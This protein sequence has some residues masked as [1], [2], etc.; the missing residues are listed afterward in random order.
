M[1]RYVALLRG[2]TPSNPNMRSEKLRKVFESL[3]FVNA[4]TVLASGNVLF[5][6]RSRNRRTLETKIER[7]LLGQLG[8][9][10]VAVVRSREQLLQL[11]AG[12]PFRSFKDAPSSR[13]NVTFLKNP[14]H[15]TMMFPYWAPDRTYGLLVL[16]EGAICSVVNLS[17]ATT[18]ELMRW[19]ESHFG[20]EITTRTWKTV[21]RILRGM[22]DS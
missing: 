13:L 7:A 19:L 15:A 12:D 17:G 5:Q 2:I 4:R 14:P 9:S 22:N 10:S 8:F 1:V 3:G 16:D 20:R 6:S 21:G 11:V 18:P